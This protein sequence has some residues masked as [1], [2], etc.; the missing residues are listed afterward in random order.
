MATLTLTKNYADTQILDESDLTEWLDEIEYFVNTTK[1][2]DDNIQNASIT[3]TSIA[4]ASVTTQLI[5][6]AAVTTAKIADSAVTAAKIPDLAITTAKIADSAVTTAKLGTGVVDTEH[7]AASSVTT[8]KVTDGAVTHAKRAALRIASSS[9]SSGAYSLST[10]STNS[11]TSI[12]NMS[13]TLDLSGNRP[14]FVG[15]MPVSTT[16]TSP[17]IIGAY[18]GGVDSWVSMTASCS[19]RLDIY[20]EGTTIGGFALNGQSI[21]PNNSLYVTGGNSG[22][23][24]SA[25]V[26]GLFLIH[27]ASPERP[28]LPI[29]A[30]SRTYTAKISNS[31]TGSSV[32]VRYFKL[33]AYEL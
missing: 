13:V 18:D 7:L 17:S 31:L 15:L 8:A 6:T 26:P 22:Q 2:N 19:L 3:S 29:S 23:H 21:I 24:H 33:I 25:G 9:S 1:L 10:A 11:M 28:A 32:D 12:T 4:D 20:Y 14:V 27:G 16:S 30:G 5:A